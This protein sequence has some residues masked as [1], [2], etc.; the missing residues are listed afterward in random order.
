[1]KAFQ[2]GS[3]SVD[4]LSELDISLPVFNSIEILLESG[5]PRDGPIV[6][7]AELRFNRGSDGIQGRM[8]RVIG[9]SKGRKEEGAG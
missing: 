6:E 3:A 2:G 8:Q 5:R 4:T 7:R 1:M 9:C